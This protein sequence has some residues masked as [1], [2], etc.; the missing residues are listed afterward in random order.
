[1]TGATLEMTR[2]ELPNDN[3]ITNENL[4]EAFT[5]NLK[6]FRNYRYS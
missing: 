3:L 4:S 6:S 5:E 2:Y 1:M